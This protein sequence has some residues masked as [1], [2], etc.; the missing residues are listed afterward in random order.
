M[1]IVLDTNA[2]ISGMLWNG[3]PRRLIQAAIARQV[4]LF[5]SEALLAE[6]SEIAGRAK[7]SHQVSRLRTTASR[8]VEEYRFLR[9]AGVSG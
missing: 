8:I 3:P 7:L 9:V 4:E 6:L 2:V 1:R 5:T